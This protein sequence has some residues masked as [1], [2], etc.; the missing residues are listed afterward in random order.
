MGKKQVFKSE[1]N[2]LFKDKFLVSLEYMGRKWRIEEMDR[3]SADGYRAAEKFPVVVV[4]DNIRSRH[5]VGAVFR[6]AD[7]LLFDHLYLCGIT[8]CPPD[9]GIHKTALGAE[10][11]VEWTYAESTVEVLSM[12]RGRGYLLL[13]IEQTEGSIML[14]CISRHVDSDRPIALVLGNEVTGVDQKAIDMCDLCIEIPQHGT[15]HSLNVS[16][17]AGMVMWEVYKLFGNTE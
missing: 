14:D 2:H 4:M 7:G 11:V 12:L 17:A 16:V 8:P 6:T 3:L 9:V 10:E 5:N 15:K 1:P 13:T